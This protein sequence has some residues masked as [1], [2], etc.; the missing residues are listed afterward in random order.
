MGLLLDAAGLFLCSYIAT[1][2]RIVAIDQMGQL[3]DGTVGLFGFSDQNGVEVRN[4]THRPKKSI[5]LN[6][7]GILAEFR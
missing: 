1:R 3:T 6:G 5:L 4:V 7:A 2:A